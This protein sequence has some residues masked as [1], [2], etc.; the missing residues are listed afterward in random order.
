MVLAGCLLANIYF[1]Y[2]CSLFCETEFD[3]T[4]QSITSIERQSVGMLN[5]TMLTTHATTWLPTALSKLALLVILFVCA[6]SVN[7]NSLLD[8]A[9]QFEDAGNYRSAVATYQQYL[10]SSPQKSA[11]TRLARIKL[12]VLQETVRYGLDT[13]I[14]PFLE[15]LDARAIGLTD[16]ALEILQQ[17]IGTHPDGHLLDDAIFM[18]AYIYMMDHYDFARAGST[19]Q[20]LIDTFPD[21]PY[22]DTSLYSIAIVNEQQGD[23]DAAVDTLSRLRDR[24]GSLSIAGL[25]WAKDTYLSRFWFER[26]D[27]RLTHLEEHKAKASRLISIEQAVGSGYQ[28]QAVVKTNGR[29]YILLLNE[30]QLTSATSIVNDRGTP[31]TPAD[32]TTYAG[33]V[34][35]LDNSWARITIDNGDLRGLI[36]LQDEQIRLQPHTTGG[37]LAD[38][39]PLLL[40]DNDGNRAEQQ[41]HVLYPPSLG[42]LTPGNLNIGDPGDLDIGGLN[43]SQPS[44][45]GNVRSV[46]SL[47]IAA[48]SNTVTKV[49][50]IGV[51]V[52]SKFNNYFAG[53]GVDEALSILNSTDGIFRQQMGL[54]LSVAKVILIED[55]VEDPM[56]LGSVTMETMMRNFREY[57]MGNTEFSD[58]DVGLATLFS[59]NKNSDAALGLAWIGSACRSDGFDV[60]VVSPYYLAE[61]LS[62]HE[63][64][65]TLGAPHD[66]DTACASQTSNIMWPFLSNGTQQQFSSCSKNSVKSLLAASSCHVDAIDLEVAIDQLS[67]TQIQVSLTNLNAEVAASDIQLAIESSVTTNDYPNG[68]TQSSPDELGCSISSLHPSQTAS[69]QIDLSQP[70]SG[71]DTLVAEVELASAL[72]IE[73]ANN[74]IELD[75]NGNTMP[76]SANGSPLPD[77]PLPDNRT[78][79]ASNDE[80]STS[81]AGSMNAAGYI[82]LMLLV[83]YCRR[84]KST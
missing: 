27:N 16:E 79:L 14:V 67:D 5:L 51:V 43:R 4:D 70:L 60:S 78:N 84:R 47:D 56:N 45:L 61:L 72:D 82:V 80:S 11:E 39:H 81:S 23:V 18:S 26:A 68:C 21:S 59:G 49:A 29:E 34:L 54:A 36:T 48:A 19:L 69:F 28:Y 64:G 31:I 8:T 77:N 71:T 25:S 38:F 65:H 41:D 15:A 10:S 52:D 37:S 9:R 24:H 58:S 75:A 66:S 35:G 62:T 2:G 50:R 55:P 13:E 12:P 44:A 22:V 3:E 6:H 46:K 7:A 73:T 74:A 30:N 33:K 1:S 32:V 53:R 57:R 63:I 40:G 20:Q 76:V 17:M 83:S 42:S